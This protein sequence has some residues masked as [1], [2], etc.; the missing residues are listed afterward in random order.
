M[1]LVYLP[2]HELADVYDNLVGE[3]TRP[4]D[5]SWEISPW[6]SRKIHQFL[7]EESQGIGDFN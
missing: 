3:Y 7:V 2:I 1:G 6:K 5:P 4:M